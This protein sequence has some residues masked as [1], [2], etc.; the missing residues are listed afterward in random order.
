MCSEWNGFLGGLWNIFEHVNVSVDPLFV[1]TVLYDQGGAEANSFDFNIVPGA[2]Y[3]LL[4]HS[5]DGRQLNSY[6]KVCSTHTGGEG[7]L[8]GRMVYYKPN[9]GGAPGFQFAFAMPMINGRK[10]QQFVPFNTFQPSGTPSDANNLVANWVQVTNINDVEARGMLVFYDMDGSVLGANEVKL[11]PGGRQ[12]FSAHR[13]GPWKVGLVEWSPEDA[14]LPIEVRNVRYYYDNPGTSNSFDTAF[15][16]EAESGSGEVI[17]APVMT[18]NNEISVLELSNTLA[19]PANAEVH[20]YD[21][22]ATER[23]SI[24]IPL[25]PKASR[26]LVLNEILGNNHRGIVAVKGDL[27]SSVLAVVM[28]YGRNSAGGIDYIYGVAAAPAIGSV[29]RSSY[30]TFLSQDSELV[31]VNPGEETRSVSLSLQG[32]SGQPI[33]LGSEPVQILP[34]GIFT[35]DVTPF[36]GRDTYGVVAASPDV[37]NSV[38]GEVFRRKGRDYVISVPL[39]Q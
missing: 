25:P 20:L 9:E 5:F 14:A 30:N 31:L 39:R 35:L 23:L 18:M 24:T 34:H 6:G 2:Q 1:H 36:V 13:F 21:E 29:L 38:V 12:D 10:G 32:N 7:A 4:V 15:Q 16:L 26:H 19:E 3:D 22:T 17:S 33:P 11:P 28:Q 37:V 27:L 8:D